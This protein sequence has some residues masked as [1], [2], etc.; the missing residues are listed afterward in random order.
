MWTLATEVECSKLGPEIEPIHQPPTS[1]LRDAEQPSGGSDGCCAN[2]LIVDYGVIDPTENDQHTHWKRP[3]TLMTCVCKSFSVGSMT[4]FIAS[5]EVWILEHPGLSYVSIELSDMQGQ[6]HRSTWSS[7]CAPHI[8][9]FKRHTTSPKSFQDQDSQ[10]WP[11]SIWPLRNYT[12][13]RS[14]YDLIPFKFLS[15]HRLMS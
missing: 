13:S 11:L 1:I 6:D 15:N 3:E 9:R 7:T 2:S 4:Q 5:V 12:G 14:R 8:T 10:L